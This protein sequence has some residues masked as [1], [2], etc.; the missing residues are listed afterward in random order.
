MRGEVKQVSLF[1]GVGGF[2]LGFERAGFESTLQCELDT[3]CRS[4]L[5]R[6]WPGVE[7]VSDVRDLNSGESPT[8]L[9]FGSPCQDLS[10]AG[11]RAGLAGSRSG[12]FHEAI[13]VIGALRPEFAVWENVGGAYSSDLGRDFGVALDSLAEAGA[14]DI[15]WRFLD[16]Q[17]FGLA[18]RR[19]R[20]FVVADF[21]GERA[22]QILLEPEG[23]PG[24]PPARREAGQEV[25]ASVGGGASGAGRTTEEIGEQ[26]VVTPVGIDGGDVGFALRS[27]A[28]HSGDKGDGGVNTTMVVAKPLAG[29]HHRTDLDNETYVVRTA[30]T[31]ANGHNVAKGMAHTLESGGGQAVYVPEVMATLNVGDAQKWGSNQW[32]NEGKAIVTGR[33]RRLTPTECERLQGFPDGWTRYGADG[34]EMSDTARYRMLGNAVPVP[35]AEWL[36][37]RIRYA[38]ETHQEERE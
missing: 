11:K 24:N 32:V 16:A 4:V 31:Q 28:S 9:S 35:F 34:K 29:H 23:V 10:V 3:S 7:R 14:V 1:T 15:A 36:A 8:V 6:H 22:G 37:W 18:Q 30:H 13:R 26:V 17:W 5:E 12:L 25:A 33:V 38:V 19:G 21:R 27:N 2:D 20:V